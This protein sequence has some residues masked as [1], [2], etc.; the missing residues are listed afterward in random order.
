[1]CVHVTLILF[2]TMETNVIV[3]FA[4]HVTSSDVSISF[5][6][7]MLL[8]DFSTW[9]LYWYFWYADMFCV[10]CLLALMFK[11]CDVSQSFISSLWFNVF[12]D[13]SRTQLSSRL[14]AEQWAGTAPCLSHS[15]LIKIN[16]VPVKSPPAAFSPDAAS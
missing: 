1:M 3:T 15:P 9:F 10:F 16:C 4:Q 5:I 8:I 13:F 12:F 6:Y 14:K 11:S 2:R 7:L